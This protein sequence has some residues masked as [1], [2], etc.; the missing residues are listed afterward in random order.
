M[1]PRFRVGADAAE[2][3]A[4][5][6]PDK[7]RLTSPFHERTNFSNTQMRRIAMDHALHVEHPRGPGLS[8]ARYVFPVLGTPQSAEPLL[9]KR[10]QVCTVKGT[11]RFALRLL[12]SIMQRFLPLPTSTAIQP[13]RLS[14]LDP[15]FSTPPSSAMESVGGSPA[16]A[17]S[18]NRLSGLRTKLLSKAMRI[19]VRTTHAVI[20]SDLNL[21]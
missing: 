5:L 13:V 11:V 17:S 20:G 19:S 4:Y 18:G 10:L 8:R 7:I 3:P 14:T 9:R 2:V 21:C 12:E 1:V 16:R 15:P 6:G